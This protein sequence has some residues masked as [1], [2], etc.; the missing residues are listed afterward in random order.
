MKQTKNAPANRAFFTEHGGSLSAY[1]FIGLLGQSLSGLSLAYAVYALLVAQIT[2]AGG[3]LIGLTAVVIAMALVVGLF[4]ETANRV[5]SRRAIKPFVVEVKDDDP[6]TMKRHK[7]INRSYQIGLVAVA[8]LSYLLSVVGS[9]YYAKDTAPEPD[10]IAIDSIGTIYDGRRAAVLE[11][12]AVDSATVAGPYD[13]QLTA[14]YA[15]FTADS[16]SLMRERE[17]YAGCARR[18]NGYCTKQRRAY[19][20]KIDERRSELATVTAANSQERATALAGLLAGRNGQLAEIKNERITDLTTARS[21]NTVAR[22]VQQDDAGLKGL[23]FIILTVAG[24]TLF[25]FMVYLQL[26]VEAGSKI[27][28][29]LEPN[30]FWGKPTVLK[31]LATT[32]GWRI[33]RGARRLIRWLFG[34]PNGQHQTAIPY[35]GLYAP[36]DGDGDPDG[37]PVTNGAVSAVENGA[38]SGTTTIK[39][40]VI[41]TAIRQCR[42]CG[43]D[44]RPKAH[45]Q[46]YCGAECKTTYHAKKHNGATFHAGK[47]R[48]R[49]A[50]K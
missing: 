35:A 48:G 30:E 32:A 46:R 25:Y 49:G 18:G 20:T 5:L 4:I 15:G 7:I 38:D 2:G 6:E 17:N 41:D 31:E 33:E 1:V 16:A 19:L 28:Y 36:N 50:S 9:S 8:L 21:A 43:N 14:A 44:Y 22:E 39:T 37:D 29:N 10:L 12:F 27:T 34:E 24:Q 42:E 3:S 40:E 26:Q 23:I 45:N 13:I 11:T 47:F